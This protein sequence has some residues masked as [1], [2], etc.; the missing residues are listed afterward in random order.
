MNPSDESKQQKDS[1]V[2]LSEHVSAIMELREHIEHLSHIIIHYIDLFGG[3]DA[4]RT[5]EMQEIRDSERIFDVSFED[6]SEFFE[7]YTS[8]SHKGELN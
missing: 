1:F 4:I 2:L 7:L 3:H 5:D 6:G 8:A